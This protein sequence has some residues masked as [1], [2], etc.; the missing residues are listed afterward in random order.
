MKINLTDIR[1][2]VM[3]S[4]NKLLLEISNNA[5]ETIIKA[6]VPNIGDWMNRTLYQLSC[7]DWYGNTTPE[8]H[9]HGIRMCRDAFGI[10][11][12]VLDSNP[13][14]KLKDFMRLRILS[15]FHINRGNGPIKYLRGIVRICCGR[16]IDMFVDCNHNALKLFKQF[17]DY[18]YH[19]NLDF[20]E[21][22]NGL[23]LDGLK[24]QIGKELRQHNISNWLK[25]INDGDSISQNGEYTIKRIPSYE[26]AH[27]YASYVDWCITYGENHYRSYTGAGEQFFFCLKNGFENVER[28]AGDNCPLDE[29]GLS[30]VSVC[31]R[32]DGTPTYITTRWNH[33]HNGEN[34]EQLR[35]LEQIEQVLGIP[36]ATFTSSL[37]PEYE[38]E[39]IPY[40]LENSKLP[41]DEIF[42]QCRPL[43]NG[44]TVV[45]MMSY[46]DRI[47]NIVKDRKLISDVW[48]DGYIPEHNNYI[49]VEYYNGNGVTYRREYNLV[50]D[51]GNF[52]FKER[53]PY[54]PEVY[55]NVTDY[56]LVARD[57]NHKNLINR[58]G[59]L[60]L[61][62]WVLSI[63]PFY[64][65]YAKIY[66]SEGDINFINKNFQQ[67]WPEFL[68]LKIIQPSHSPEWSEG[69]FIVSN[70]RNQYT[71]MSIETGKA[72]MRGN[73]DKWFDKCESFS[74]GV[75]KVMRFTS[76]ED[77]NKI[78]NLIT[79]NGEY[80]SDTWF[81]NIRATQNNY[82]IV[83]ND[84]GE[85]NLI[86]PDKQMFFK[87]WIFHVFFYDGTYGCVTVKKDGPNYVL[88][89]K[90]SLFKTSY[91]V[92]G[93][94]PN[95]TFLAFD[96]KNGYRLHLLDMQGNDII[97][98][99]F[100][101]V[102]HSTN[103]QDENG[104]IYTADDILNKE[105]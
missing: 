84:N 32:P 36:A 92:Y 74:L 8:P 81:S 27:Q 58:N 79:K 86:T 78:Y 85:E 17:I 45:T 46:G 41:L 77:N 100:M 20:D 96:T 66:N 53:L 104:N 21:D 105:W 47:Y 19:N 76:S 43:D 12:D 24:E 39:D 5:I 4:C 103:F 22:L 65:E 62:D 67:M 51:N 61:S 25:N 69:V 9:T 73:P 54:R 38:I 95:G 63:T 71:Y 15:E 48:F 56:F 98:G 13:N 60:L 7:L 72:L 90:K 52:I 50:D 14:M 2:M 59:D 64:G 44:L 83:V 23:S 93:R 10:S 16:D 70:G 80:A 102:P 34:N 35:S 18:I 87:K 29:Y 40:I 37:R 89:G 6:N 57:Y 94:N 68:D 101:G 55:E 75:G 49:S 99:G 3:E 82:Y 33:A 11:R 28:K 1:N 31:I 26:A 91:D 30:M 42:F 88:K 97:P